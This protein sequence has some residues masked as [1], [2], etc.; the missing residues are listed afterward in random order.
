VVATGVEPKPGSTG[1]L[2]G[3]ASLGRSSVWI[4]HAQRDAGEARKLSHHAG[5]AAVE[6]DARRWPRS[7]ARKS[8]K[9]PGIKPRALQRFGIGD[10]AAVSANILSPNAANECLF[11]ASRD[12]F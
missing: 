10:R 5:M 7:R 11:H 2:A 12:M 4:D 8:A 1:A 9:Q 6:N 3:K